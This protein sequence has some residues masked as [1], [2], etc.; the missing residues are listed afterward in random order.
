MSESGQLLEI[1]VGLS[2]RCR[3]YAHY[4]PF[5]ETS[6]RGPMLEGLALALER[7]DTRDFR[8]SGGACW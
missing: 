2:G 5:A 8:Q 3:S 1:R 4:G 7:V 6:L